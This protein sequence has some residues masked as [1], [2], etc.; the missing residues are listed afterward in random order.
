MSPVI[1][2]LSGEHNFL[3]IYRH[4]RRFKTSV[5][6]L[7]YLRLKSEPTRVAVVVS[8]KISN[9]ATKRNLYKRRLWACLRQQ[10][11]LLPVKGYNVIITALPAIK[12]LTYQELNREIEGLIAKLK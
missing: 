3:N 6:Q 11:Q 8:K 7:A 9:L 4:G 10:R 2:R 5:A 12:N 1:A